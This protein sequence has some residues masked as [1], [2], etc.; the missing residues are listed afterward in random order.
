M[1][2]EAYCFTGEALRTGL[3][4]MFNE[5][6]TF[7]NP[8]RKEKQD[9]DLEYFMSL[10]SLK[11]KL[12][13][14]IC[15]TC[16]DNGMR[17]YG[18]C[19]RCTKKQAWNKE[20]LETHTFI[21]DDKLRCYHSDEHNIIKGLKL[22]LPNEHPYLYYGVELEIEFEG[23]SVFDGEEDEDEYYD[24][25]MPTGEIE[26]ILSKFS[27]I[28]DGLF[29]YERDGS[30][31]NGVEFISRPCSYAFWTCKETVEKLERGFKY[32]V[33]NGAWIDQPSRNGMHIH[34]SQKFFECG[35]RDGVSV[36]GA[37]QNFRW[38]FQIFQNEVEKLGGRKYTQYCMADKDIAKSRLS[39]RIGGYDDLNIE[40]T[41]KCKLK[42]GGFLPCENHSTSV[43][44]SRNTI[45]ARVFKSTV[46]YKQML[47]NIE[48]V[49]N[50]AHAVREQDVDKTLNDILHTKDN[51]FLDE[52]IQK[53]RMKCKKNK[54]EFDIE[55]QNVD[56]INIEFEA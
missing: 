44:L 42:K 24:E 34:L 48:L 21:V 3:D 5:W 46:D 47:S 50:F 2:N 43:T 27:K 52:H 8:N 9:M 26:T 4:N 31:Q 53:V 33:E 25:E 36:Q 14:I 30:L 55:K 32:L 1:Y 54:E 7:I 45:E 51:L 18:D 19:A 10:D 16:K 23:F 40:A 15:K 13:P 38:L 37:L 17:V 6:T 35:I 56:E 28:T 11:N 29:V 39:G 12:K 49:R 20:Y 22:R 41:Y